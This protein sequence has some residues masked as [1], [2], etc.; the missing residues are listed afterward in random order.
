VPWLLSWIVIRKQNQK[1]NFNFLPCLERSPQRLCAWVALSSTI[2][3]LI[4][5]RKQRFRLTQS[6][7]YRQ[8]KRLKGVDELVETLV[9]SGVQLKALVWFKRLILGSSTISSESE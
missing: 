5:C 4:H 6:Q 1:P 2:W 9:Q 8:T 7:K 3:T